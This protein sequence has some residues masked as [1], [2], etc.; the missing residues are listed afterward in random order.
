MI[1]QVTPIGMAKSRWRFYILFVVSSMLSRIHISADVFGKVTNFTNALFFWSFLPE[2]RK[3]PLEEMN[4][5]FHE[6]PLFIGNR[7]IETSAMQH[8]QEV[9]MKQNETDISAS[10]EYAEQAEIESK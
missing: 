4:I 2:T 8:L 6:A 3:L 5:L 9:R 1:G 7:K 10:N